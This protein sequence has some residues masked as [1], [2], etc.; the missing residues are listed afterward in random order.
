MYVFIIIVNL[1]FN[2]LLVKNI[3]LSLYFVQVQ[4]TKSHFSSPVLLVL[5]SCDDIRELRKTKNSKVYRMK[6]MLVKRKELKD[7]TGENETFL[8]KSLPS[9]VLNAFVE[10]IVALK[11]IIKK[12]KEEYN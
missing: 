2:G 11:S 4:E 7:T 1:L 5:T 9:K 12:N 6:S 3:R 10:S 8:S